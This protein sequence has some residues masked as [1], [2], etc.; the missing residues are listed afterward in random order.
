[1]APDLDP[2][3]VFDSHERFLPLAVESVEAV[4]G[5]EVIA[6][7][8]SRT[9]PIDLGSL[10]DDAGA[11]LNFPPDPEGYQPELYRR[12][13]N[14]GYVHEVRGGG[15]LWRQYWLWYLY[16]PKRVVV[17]GEH[18]GDWEFVQ[19]GFAGDIPVCMTASQHRAGG[20]RFWWDLEL[21][22]G[23]PVVYPARDSHANFFTPVDGLKW[24]EDDGDGKGAVLD[25]IEWRE[26]GP[27]V[28]WR[29]RWGNSTGKGRSPQSPGR[30]GERWRRPHRYHSKSRNEVSPA[31]PAGAP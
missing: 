20:S 6:A 22:D 3:F 2:I 9:E 19:I 8:G 18:E 31:L 25:E 14:V 10:P 13:G 15:L 5:A 30:Q 26:F 12:L 29:G 28:T 1:V 27:W 23:R 21:R 7:D 24:I 16:N 4:K 11:R 17:T